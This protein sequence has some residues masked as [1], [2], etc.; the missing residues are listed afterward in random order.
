MS[1]GV[2]IAG[3][4]ELEEQQ[5]VELLRICCVL[6]KVCRHHLQHKYKRLGAHSTDKQHA[7]ILEHLN[8]LRRKLNAWFKVQQTYIPGVENL[9]DTKLSAMKDCAT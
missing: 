9:R 4:I 3:G 6:I 8:T 7:D 1:A 2:M 5:Y